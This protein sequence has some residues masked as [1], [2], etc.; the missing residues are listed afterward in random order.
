MLL[1]TKIAVEQKR[2]SYVTM[3]GML[4]NTS[5]CPYNIYFSLDLAMN[6]EI[7]LEG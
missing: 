4:S 6:V 5:R 3:T 2:V 1:S 7:F